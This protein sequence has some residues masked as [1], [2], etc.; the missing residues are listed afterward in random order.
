MRRVGI[1]EAARAEDV[2][3]D[4]YLNVYYCSELAGLDPLQ[5]LLRGLVEEVIVVLDEMAASLPG[6]LDQRLEFL[7]G[8]GGRLFDDHVGASVER[9]HNRP[10]MGGR[11]RG[12]VDHV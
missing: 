6:A 1:G 8:R 7:E 10:E 2:E 9:V 11:R 3:A 4:E 12:D 5:N